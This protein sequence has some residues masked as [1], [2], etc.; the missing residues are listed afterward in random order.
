MSHF[1]G[2]APICASTPDGND[3]AGESGSGRGVCTSCVVPLP[4]FG[5]AFSFFLSSPYRVERLHL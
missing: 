2:F 3:E 5:I 4:V 1:F